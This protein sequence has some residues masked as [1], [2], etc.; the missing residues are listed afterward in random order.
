[1]NI[2]FLS[3]DLFPPH[4]VDVK[5]LF[6]EEISGR[7]HHIDWILQSEAPCS[8]PYET[9]WGGGTVWVGARETGS[10]LLHSLRTHFAGFRND[11][12]LLRLVRDKPYDLVIIKDKFVSAALAVLARKFWGGSIVFWLS[13]PFP[14]E[15]LARSE[16]PENNHR[17]L[18]KI[19]GLVFKFLLYKIILPGSKHVFVQSE[20]MKSDVAEMG[21]DSAKL[22]PVPMGIDSAD[23]KVPAMSVERR[24][25]PHSEACFLYLGILSRLRQLDFLV[26][27]LSLVV[28]TKPE[29][30]LYL[31]GKG[32]SNEDEAAIQA[33]IHRLGLEES[34][35]MTGHLPREKAMQYA[36]EANVCV[37]PFAP[38][39]ILKS[40]SPTKLVEYLA[41]GKPV[42]ANDHP[43]QRQIIEE[44][45]A[46]ICVGWDER[47]FADAILR[48]LG[49]EELCEEMSK[50]GPTYVSEFRTY[51]TI[52]DQ[53]ES[54]LVSL[55]E[56]VTARSSEDA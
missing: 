5:V 48:L 23:M 3:S 30:K 27:V 56:P 16:Q 40:T 15:Y 13:W 10:S 21:I 32:E 54:V 7:G 52:A 24:L 11:L 8:Q 2:L 51:E 9:N 38:I 37:S 28:K 39:P 53:V 42:V 25:I 19:R 47:E 46:G 6:G 20:Q 45:G 50:N 43:E 18:Y 55:V 36:K 33:E 1:M 12:I 17:V 44:S 26:R 34:V 35:V 41:L 29:V 49:D 22:T 4:R 14:E 31:V